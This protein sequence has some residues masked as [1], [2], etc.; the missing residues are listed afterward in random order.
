MKK[1]LASYEAEL[2][3]R[4]Y[5][6]N[7]IKCYKGLVRLYIMHFQK[8]PTKISEDE[9]KTYLRESSSQSLLKQRI[10]AIKRFYE[11][12]IKDPLKFKYIQY[13]RTEQHLPDILSFAEVQRL[14]TAC[15]NKKH[16]AILFLFYSTGMREGEVINL[17]VKDIDSGLMQIHIRQA[18][19]KKDRIVPLSEPTLKALRE[20]FK[21]EKP[22]NYLFNGQF[23]DQ[24]SATSI[25]Q[26]VKKYANIAKI[27]KRV[28]PHLLRHCSATHSYESGTD[29]AIIQKILGHKNQK[30]TMIYT[31]LSN[32]LISKVRTPD[33]ALA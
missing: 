29:L 30:T 4:N 26:F 21:E 7:T 25:Q 6:Y 1:L 33:M 20:H 22:R 10:G 17:K 16:K 31:H 11:L 18:K 15:T 5:C 19:G 28:Y 8:H 13:P 27:K 23:S 14:F 3:L 24:Y 32:N 9:I 2:Q 12:V